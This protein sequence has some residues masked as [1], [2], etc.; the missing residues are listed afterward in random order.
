[1]KPYFQDG[2]ATIYH[3][4]CREVL[5]QLNPVHAVITDPVWPNCPEGLL[6]GC[7]NPNLLKE[8]LAL[9]FSDRLVIVLRYDSDPRLLKAVPK[10]FPFFRVQ[11]LPY[12]MPGYNG[13]KLGGDEIAYCFGEPIPSAPGRRV[14]PG[15]APNITQPIRERMNGHPCPRALKHFEWLVD[16]WS[17]PG[18]TVLD[19]FMG[20]GTTIE[21]ARAAGRKCIGIEIEEK[22]CEIAASRLKQG[23][24]LEA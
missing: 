16:W 9:T 13:R 1:M 7:D 21:A 15:R 24:L 19:P 2:Y 23:V 4:D 17:T 14:I 18:E 5:P 8:A 6:A 22:Y 10:R 11:L 20:S 3:G 12:V